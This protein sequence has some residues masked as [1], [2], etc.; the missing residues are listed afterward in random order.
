M[1][2]GLA[3]MHLALAAL[4]PVW[5]TGFLSDGHSRPEKLPARTSWQRRPRS[6]AA[7][8]NATRVLELPGSNFAAYTV[9]QRRRAGHSRPHRPAVLTREVLP[10]GSPSS[11]N[12]LDA[13]D[14]RYQQGVFEPASLAPVARLFG[15]GTVAVRSDLASDDRFGLRSPHPTVGRH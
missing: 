10:S 13:I 15:V 8:A 4:G 6:I 11:V 3:V 2:A 1:L 5:Q 9:G 14:G 12:L 7:G